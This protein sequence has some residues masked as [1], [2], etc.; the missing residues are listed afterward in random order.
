M[1]RFGGASL[2]EKKFLGEG[3]S[4][5]VHRQEVDSGGPNG[6]QIVAAGP[7][8]LPLPNG[9]AREVRDFHRELPV[10]I[11]EQA[12]VQGIEGQWAA[13]GRIASANAH[14]TGRRIAFHV[15]GLVIGR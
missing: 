1:I 15:I 9:P 4:G 5:P 6:L 13:V 12:P 11:Q 7:V 14:G 3:F 10:D 8:S 2:P